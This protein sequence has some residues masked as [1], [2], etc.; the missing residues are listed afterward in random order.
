MCGPRTR[1]YHALLLPTSTTG[2]RWVLVNGVDVVVT[3][4]AGQFPLSVQRYVGGAAAPQTEALLQEFSSEPWPRWR[5]RLPDGTAIEA[6]LLVQQGDGVTLMSWKLQPGSPVTGPVGLRV[7]PFFAGRDYHAL[8]HEN[9]GFHFAAIPA[10]S[11]DRWQFAPYP[12][13]P[14]IVLAASGQYRHDPHWYRGF[15]YAEELARGFDAVEDL[16]AP[17]ELSFLLAGAA[18]A[19]GTATTEAFLLL[20]AAGDDIASRLPAPEL[21]ATAWAQQIRAAE[22]T[23]RAGFASPIERAADAYFITTPAGATVIAGYPWFTDWGR[24]TFIAL[25]GLALA[26]TGDDAR[27]QVARAVLLR[28]ADAVSEGMLPNRFI[29]LGEAPEYNS[30]DAALWF[31]IAVHDY[32]GLAGRA[33]DSHGD[34]RRRLVAAVAAI[35]D[36]HLHGTRARIQVGDDGLLAA[37]QPGLQLTWMD[38]KVG[39]WVVT[40]RVGKPVEV[41]ALWL[42]ALAVGVGTGGPRAQVWQQVFQQGCASFATRFWDPRHGRLHDVVDVDHRS[43]IV[44]SSFRPNQIFAVGGLPLALLDGERA[45]AVVDAVEAA[46]VVPLGLRTLAPDD[47]AYCG[48]YH[49]NP[50]ERDAAYHQGTVWP[51]LMGPFV[52]AWVRVRNNSAQAKSEARRRFLAPLLQHLGDV[53]VGHVSEIADGDFPH[54]AGGCPFQAW[55]LG[56]LLRLDRHVLRIT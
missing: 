17:G 39:D 32:L 2:Q 20:A 15:E 55:S 25:R 28:W 6:E 38:A 44:D 12:G 27:D 19:A 10:R 42:N 23:R 24:D 7:R 52:E 51:W 21:T 31:V 43:G 4:P 14:G 8:H 35:L 48:R 22:H 54:R 45:R 29:Q 1:R 3:T 30:V 26:R 40:P 33:A 56:E 34:D 47:P 9:P 5:Y 53:G 11:A 50:R 41:Q 13:V 16:V 46:L 37:G 49:G 36:G 18:G